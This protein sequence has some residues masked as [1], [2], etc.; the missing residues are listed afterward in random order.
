LLV[1]CTGLGSVIRS[2]CRLVDSNLDSGDD[3]K[4]ANPGGSNSSRS[5]F[6][7]K[8]QALVG[9]LRIEIALN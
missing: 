5:K 2:R 6:R 7:K 8:N 3:K 1:N 9:V 4:L